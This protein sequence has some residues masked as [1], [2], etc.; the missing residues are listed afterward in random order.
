VT[1]TER[2]L[3]ARSA[4]LHSWARTADFSLRTKPGRDAAWR[5]LCDEVDPDHVLSEAERAK[6]ADY[7]R[8]ARMTNLSRLAAKARRAKREAADATNGDAS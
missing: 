6:R 1:E 3:R 7:L 2:S 8:R 5:K 4:V